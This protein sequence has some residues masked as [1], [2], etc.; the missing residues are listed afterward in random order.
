MTRGFLSEGG[1]RRETESDDAGFVTVDVRWKLDKGD[2]HGFYDPEDWSKLIW[3]PKR[4]TKLEGC[5]PP[6]GLGKATIPV[7]LAQRK[8]LI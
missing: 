6:D 2:A 7:W 5:N 8:G 4:L 1:G 3:L